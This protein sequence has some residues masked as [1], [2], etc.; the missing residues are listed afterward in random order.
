MVF[1]AGVTRTATC[2]A[3]TGVDVTTGELLAGAVLVERVGWLARLI[4]EVGQE[5]VDGPWKPD[6]IRAIGAKEAPG[7]AWMLS[8][9]YKAVACLWGWSKPPAGVYAVSRVVWM[10]QELAGRQLRSAGYRLGV[11][12]QLL[13]KALPQDGTDQVAGENWRRRIGHHLNN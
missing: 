9:A 4:A 3:R 6:D 7:G 5:V 10:G 8:F 12:E 1:V 13:A 11:V 2:I